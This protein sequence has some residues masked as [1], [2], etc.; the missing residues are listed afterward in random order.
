VYFKGDN[1]M[2]CDV[3]R[4]KTFI[5]PFFL[6]LSAVRGCG[7]AVVDRKRLDSCIERRRGAEAVAEKV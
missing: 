3:K 2:C 6:L 5:F 7:A 1:A 4:T